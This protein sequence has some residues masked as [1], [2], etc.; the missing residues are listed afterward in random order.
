MIGHRRAGSGSGRIYD[1]KTLKNK[2]VNPERWEPSGVGTG[3]G[4]VVEGELVGVSR[5]LITDSSNKKDHYFILYIKPTRIHKRKFDS[6]GAEIEAN[7]SDSVFFQEVWGLLMLWRS[8]AFGIFPA[9]EFSV[10]EIHPTLDLWYDGRFHSLSEVGVYSL[11]TTDWTVLSLSLV[12]CSHVLH[13][14]IEVEEKGQTDK[15][16]VE[17]LKHL[18][19]KSQLVRIF[20]MYTPNQSLSFWISE[21]EMDKI[22]LEIGDG[23]KTDG[24]GPFIFTLAKMDAGTVTKCNF[25]GDEKLGASWTDEVFG[26]KSK[27]K[28]EAKASTQEEGA[29][30]DEWVRYGWRECPS[31]TPIGKFIRYFKEML[32]LRIINQL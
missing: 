2:P 14:V 26:A 10:S 30:E 19:N 29:D 16:S 32:N 5:H 18:I 9:R 8:S 28:Q 23:L 24:E 6:H 31:V 20:R 11:K 1:N 17:E 27:N 12:L 4:A 15:I 25:S 13:C 22:E 3:P 21:G 7:F